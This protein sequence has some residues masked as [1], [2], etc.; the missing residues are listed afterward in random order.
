M[1]ELLHKIA[2]SRL[3]G[4]T[5]ELASRLLSA[6][7]SEEAFFAAS[8]HQVFQKTGTTAPSLSDVARREALKQ[9]EDEQRFMSAHH[10]RALFFTDAD[11][12]QRLLRC[13]DA[14]LML[15]GVGDTN[16]NAPH[17]ISII[18]TRNATIY[19][20][21]FINTLIDSLAS[22]L[23]GLV[24]VSGLALGCDVTSHKAALRNSVPTVGV[25]AHGLDTLYPAENRLTARKM[26]EAGGMIVTDYV[27]GTRPHR[28]NF[29]ARN[30]IVA[31]LS[32]ATIVVESAADKGGALHLSLIHISEP[33]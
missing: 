3:K 22:R 16:L 1:T 8:E 33:T 27:H 14:P 30:R 13:D 4:L 5:P 26:V 23:P 31:G 32:D 25:V 17:I 2:F 29:L 11:Y 18:G 15:Y 7:G 6:F 19:G 10:V 24:V 21:N 28:G 20:V 9:A 12:P